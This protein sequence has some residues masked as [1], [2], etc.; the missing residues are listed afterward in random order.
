MSSAENISLRPAER[1]DAAAIARILAAGREQT[2]GLQEGSAG[3]RD[4][5]TW[6]Q[7]REGIWYIED[8]LNEGTYLGKEW[9]RSQV[10]VDTES[11]AVRGVMTAQVR[12]I[13]GPRAVNLDFMFVDPESQ[14]QGIGNTL[15]TDFNAWA[16]DRP[17]TLDVLATN[18]RAQHL[19]S[20]HGFE[21]VPGQIEKRT[22][23]DGGTLPFALMAK[24]V[25]GLALHA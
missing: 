10:A 22:F 3:Y 7:S 12:D 24:N 16:G 14:G 25:G 13:H 20:K 11:D 1:S 2:Y 17:Q 6:Q 8:Y 18:E 23:E 19:Y 4:L 9:S 21:T 15:M 5:V